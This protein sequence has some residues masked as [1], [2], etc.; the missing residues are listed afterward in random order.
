M[1]KSGSVYFAA[2]GLDFD[3]LRP[4]VRVEA[5]QPIPSKVSDKEVRELYAAKLVKAVA[6]N[7]GAPGDPMVAVMERE[8]AH[9]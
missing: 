2:V 6:V 4:P 7:D 3:G 9:E 1:S 5:G 8:G